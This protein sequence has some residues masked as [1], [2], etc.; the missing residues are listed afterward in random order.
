M[1]FRSVLISILVA[2]STTLAPAADQPKPVNPAFAH[3]K[4]LAGEWQ[5]DS[6]WGGKSRVKYEILAG[7]SAVVETFTDDK[8]GT[9]NA[10][11]TVYTPDGDGVALT[12]YCMA[13]NQPTMKAKAL[14][15]GELKFDFVSAANLAGPNAGHMRTAQFKFLGADRFV[16]TWNFYENGQLK[17]AETMEYTRVR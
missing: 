5:A 10:M 13:G 12:H 17:N 14:N 8:L 9:S 4:G 7:G 2:V 6:P 3:I 1:K 15:G 16:S 11:V